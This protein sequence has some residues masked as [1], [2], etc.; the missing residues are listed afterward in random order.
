MNLK[1][2]VLAAAAEIASMK[3]P[4]VQK[5]LERNRYHYEAKK[6]KELVDAVEELQ[7]KERTP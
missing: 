3:S 7:S 1:E 2:K 5:I 6:V 4:S